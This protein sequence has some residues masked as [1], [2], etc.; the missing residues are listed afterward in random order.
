MPDIAESFLR[1]RSTATNAMF[2]SSNEPQRD[3]ST[4]LI[5]D[6]VVVIPADIEA[7]RPFDMRRVQAVS[8]LAALVPASL[9]ASSEF[10]F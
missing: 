2:A 3:R 8:T 9:F 5:A 6:S 4:S 7:L 1:E 10:R